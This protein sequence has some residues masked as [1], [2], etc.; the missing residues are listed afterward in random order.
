LRDRLIVARELLNESGSCF[1]Q[2]SD[3]NVHL[4]RAVLD[5]VFLA[6]NQVATIVWKK[7]TPDAKTIRN[8]FNYLLWYSK[9]INSTKVRK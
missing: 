1:V 3:E 9:D 8:A 5:E 7:G 4:V 2:I 6:E